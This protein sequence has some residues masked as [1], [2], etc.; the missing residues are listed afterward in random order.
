MSSVLSG[1]L[2]SVVIMLYNAVVNII[3]IVGLGEKD[4]PLIYKKGEEKKDSEVEAE[5]ARVLRIE[6]VGGVVGSERRPQV[7]PLCGIRGER[8]LAPLGILSDIKARF[9]C[10][11]CMICTEDHSADQCRRDR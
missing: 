9:L 1:A 4:H 5:H 3:K 6:V 7:D 8:Q 10:S 2:I 11:C